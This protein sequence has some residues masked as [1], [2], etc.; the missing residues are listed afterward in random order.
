M[1]PVLVSL[2][3]FTYDVC[4]CVSIVYVPM[5]VCMHVSVYVCVCPLWT[6]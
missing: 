4:M 3:V 1:R 6:L 5:N 2:H